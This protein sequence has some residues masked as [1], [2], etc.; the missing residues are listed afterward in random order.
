MLAERLRDAGLLT[1]A[2][3]P[4]LASALLAS[5]ADGLY[6]VDRDGLVQLLNPA[7]EHVLGWT[8]RELLGR[9]AH[10][11]FH[12][13]H[14]DGAR[15]LRA[16]CPLLG[17]LRTGVAVRVQADAFTRK[18][19]SL[20]EVSYSSSPVIQHGEVMGAVVVFQD[21]SEGQ[22]VERRAAVLAS[23]R[24]EASAEWQ[25]NLLPSELPT[26]PRLDLAVSF[27]PVGETAVVGG[28]F[29]DVID[30][31]GGHLLALGDVRGKGPGAAAIAAMVRYGLRG[32]G[33]ASCEAA[34]LLGLLNRELRTHPS[35]RFCTLAL[36]YVVSLDDGRMQATVSS[37]GHPRPVLVTG[38]GHAREVGGSAPLLGVFDEMDVETERV[39]LSAGDRLV[40]FSD[41]LT[42]AR[43]RIDGRLFDVVQAV[44]DLKPGTSA[45]TVT[46]LERAA[47]VL[48]VDDPPDDVAVLVAR[49]TPVE[50]L[51]VAAAVP[52]GAAPAD[53]VMIGEVEA[54]FRESNQR[55]MDGRPATE[56]RVAV[57]CECGHAD[58]QQLID[59]PTG[60]YARTRADD[61][62]FVV[63]VGHE[64]A[65]AESVL[66]RHAGFVIV[67]KHGA[68]G[69]V[70]EQQK[71]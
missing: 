33:Q 42:D 41:G 62:C 36:V 61:R 65:R 32:A 20:V 54:A 68:A 13:Q 16:D 47:G 4:E 45:E 10:D 19:G 2:R 37:A 23:E 43:R 40:L 70:A 44:G 49:L 52:H 9:H 5:I 12:F 48:D 14:E 22:A 17:V 50:H 57:T 7:G 26:I 6:L 60:L 39:D 25:R 31:P 46:H 58:C 63:L 29:Y 66:E 1:I 30:C 27:R 55:L 24:E 18:D 64:I 15:Y 59:V 71:P 69:E 34:H 3:L 21:R 35:S 51:P 56:P 53:P 11:T 67:R 8:E 38:D 28:D